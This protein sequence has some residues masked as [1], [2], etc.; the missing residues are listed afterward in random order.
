[1]CQQVLWLYMRYGTHVSFVLK[2]CVYKLTRCWEFYIL[3][4]F[5][6]PL[7][8]IVSRAIHIVVIQNVG[9]PISWIPT[10]YIQYFCGSFNEYF[11]SERDFIHI[12]NVYTIDAALQ[13]I[14]RDLMNIF[15]IHFFF[16]RRMVL[17]LRFWF[18]V[19]YCFTNVLQW[20]CI[21]SNI[22]AAL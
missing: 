9:N 10:V 19:D 3:D 17:S 20:T 8:C 4:K 11:D 7:R 12:K 16:S 1:M 13:H 6:K 15:W 21:L 18:K 14:A 2:F 5:L 22:V